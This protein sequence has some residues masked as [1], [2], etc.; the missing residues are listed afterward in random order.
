MKTFA[1]EMEASLVRTIKTLIAE[2]VKSSGSTHKTIVSHG[3]SHA[4][5]DSQ[6]QGKIKIHRY[7]HPDHGHLTTI[8]GEGPTEWYYHKQPTEQTTHNGRVGELDKFLGAVQHVYDKHKGKDAVKEEKENPR[9]YRQNIAQPNPKIRWS[10]HYENGECPDC[11]NRIPV[12]A[13]S[14]EGC[15]NC[16]HVFTPHRPV[17]D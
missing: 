6:I 17:D 4:G 13:K 9:T 1:Q 5:S 3:W 8:H 15:K 11:G 2:D 12:K 16:G 7:T 10:D 14:G